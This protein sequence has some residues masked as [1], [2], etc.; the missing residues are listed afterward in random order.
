MDFIFEHFW[1]SCGILCGFGNAIY[2]R[3]KLQ[4]SVSNGKLS[5]KEANWFGV[6]FSLSI[7]IP[8]LI[9]WFLQISSG[10]QATHNFETWLPL[11]RNIGS[12]VMITCWGT[13]FLWVWFLK[14]AEKL[15]N[16]LELAGHKPRFM[17]HPFVF[18]GLAI[19]ILVMAIF[20]IK[21]RV[22]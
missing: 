7:F 2:F 4:N 22:L 21:N 16:Y 11:Q 20:F 14:G 15:S 1:L 19:A 8:C 5:I 13:F 18:K 6:G 17:N 12:A 3:F 10:P 9:F